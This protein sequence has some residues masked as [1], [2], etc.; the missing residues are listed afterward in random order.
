MRLIC[1]LILSA[2]WTCA[3][4][5]G[6]AEVEPLA[7]YRDG[8]RAPFLKTH[9]YE[10][11]AGETPEGKLRLDEATTAR[12]M[13]RALWRSVVRQLTDGN[14]PPEGQPQSASWERDAVV[15][16]LTAMLAD[17][18]NF[19]SETPPQVTMRRLNRRQ[20]RNTIRDLFGIDHDPTA[21]L[22]ADEIG[23]GF[24]NIGDVLTVSPT[25]R[26][27]ESR[28]LAACRTCRSHDR[29]PAL[30]AIR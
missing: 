7:E 3:I 16:G 12:P 14:M 24:D 22:P 11:H 23:Y 20:Y 17:C 10:C 26:R 27:R 9:C 18:T 30:R 13:S 4:A 28:S 6:A 1:T 25:S 8:R 21:L 19:A 5:A 29:R 2:A 15:E